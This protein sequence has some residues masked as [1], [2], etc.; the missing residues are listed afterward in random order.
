M[1]FYGVYITKTVSQC[2]RDLSFKGQGQIGYT[3]LKIRQNLY[4]D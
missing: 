3:S 1:V 2:G 4:Y